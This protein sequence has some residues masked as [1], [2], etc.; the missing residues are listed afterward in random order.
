MVDFHAI[1][2]VIGITMELIF[3]GGNNAFNKEFELLIIVRG[4]EIEINV[5]MA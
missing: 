3:I 2:I 4:I 5:T 1:C